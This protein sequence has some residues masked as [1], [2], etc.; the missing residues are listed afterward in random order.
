MACCILIS[1]K[2]QILKTLDGQ[3][4]RGVGISINQVIKVAKEHRFLY[5]LGVERNYDFLK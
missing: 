1:A 3:S 5:F 4:I 2:S